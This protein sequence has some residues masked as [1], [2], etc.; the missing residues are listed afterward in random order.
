MTFTTL[1]FLYVAFRAKHFA[2]DFLLQ[3]DWMALNKGKPGKDGYKALLFHAGMHGLGTLL[4]SI[5]FAPV[6]WWLGPVDFVLHGLIDRIKGGITY[7]MGWEP[8]D[9]YFWWALGADQELHNY[10][11]MAYIV[12]MVVVSGGLMV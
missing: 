8:A 6:L 10:T 7:K 11:H 9:T 5:L 1:L 4:L 2:C 3:T 12:L